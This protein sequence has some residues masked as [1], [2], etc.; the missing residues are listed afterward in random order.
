[1]PLDPRTGVYYALHGAPEGV[2][3][4][5]TLPLMA[6]FTDLFGAEMAPVLAGYLD[7]LTDRY[8]VLLVDYPSIGA[9][10]DI[11]PQDLTADR[12]ELF[13]K[14]AANELE[15]VAAYGVNGSV[16]VKDG[17]RT[18]TGA[19]LTYTARTETY[20]M[21]GTPVVAIDNTP[22]DCKR[23]E[24]A[25]LTFRRGVLDSMSTEGNGVFPSKQKTFAC[26]TETR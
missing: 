16:I 20:L 1:M 25:V 23:S 6:S 14:T 4:L 3:L 17:S 13:L 8:R 18:A 22:P 5:I 11:A 15:R 21:S 2:P 26:T 9:S 10:H 24:G 7:R 12:V 19:R